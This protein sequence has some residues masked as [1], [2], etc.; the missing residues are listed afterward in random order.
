MSKENPW[1][2]T[3]SSNKNKSLFGIIAFVILLLIVASASNKS[4]KPSSSESNYEEPTSTSIVACKSLIN[5]KT[6][7]DIDRLS[8][9][10]S[11]KGNPVITYYVDADLVHKFQCIDGSL[12]LY[13][14]GA[15]MWMKM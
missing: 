9:I 7:Y 14:K 4:T 13:A 1:K 12:E 6:I 8:Y 10:G 2:N 11:N 3:N 15:G 5:R